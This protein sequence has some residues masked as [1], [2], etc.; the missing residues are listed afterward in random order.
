METP[1]SSSCASVTVAANLSSSC[2][3]WLLL[4]F[5][6][7]GLPIFFAQCFARSIARFANRSFVLAL[8]IRF[9]CTYNSLGTIQVRAPY[10]YRHRV[11]LLQRVFQLLFQIPDLPPMTGHLQ[12]Q[13]L[14]VV[15]SALEEN[16]ESLTLIPVKKSSQSG[17]TFSPSIGFDTRGATSCQY[18][19][20]VRSLS[21]IGG[22][23]RSL[24]ADLIENSRGV[25][26]FR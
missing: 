13:F 6:S 24:L 12:F 26:R 15:K 25:W 9:S 4:V 1:I 7:L 22:S 2:T 11:L 14:A 3:V 17:T 23:M 10:S 5:A 21:A 8:L 19:V 16:T 18:S 20:I